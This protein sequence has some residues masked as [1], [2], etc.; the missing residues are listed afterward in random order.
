MPLAEPGAAEALHW[1]TAAGLG[2]RMPGGYFNGPYGDGDRTGVY[3]V[4]LRFTA[5]LLQD[6]RFT[7][8]APVI[9][10][11][12]REAA[13]Q[14]LAYWRAGALVLAPQPHADVLRET[15]DKLVGRPGRR[16]DGVWVWDLHD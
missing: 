8:V 6:T 4:P 3:G 7:G 2:F 12:A 1:Q 13:A 9:D 16:V 14:D 15:V 5:S 11:A 10:T